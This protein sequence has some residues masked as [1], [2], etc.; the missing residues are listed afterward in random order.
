MEL[1]LDRRRSRLGEP[2][3]KVGKAGRSADCR[4]GREPV[5]SI[6]ADMWSR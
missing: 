4:D 5:E 6:I 3:L 2:G 1:T